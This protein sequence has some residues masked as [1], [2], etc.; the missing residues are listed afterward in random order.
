MEKKINVCVCVGG[1]GGGGVLHRIELLH[2]GVKKNKKK[3]AAARLFSFVSTKCDED[4]RQLRLGQ[5]WW[6]GDE[7]VERPITAKPS[8][9]MSS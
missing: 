8:S 4:P 3:P 9:L 7:K 2:Q 5:R 6:E 1:E